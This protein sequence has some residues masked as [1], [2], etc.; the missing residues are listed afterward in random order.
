MIH[1]RL[2]VKEMRKIFI[3]QFKIF[4]LNK[5]TALLQDVWSAY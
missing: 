4:A 2:K 5:T 1:S 3:K